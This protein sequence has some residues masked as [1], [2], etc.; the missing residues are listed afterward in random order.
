MLVERSLRG[1]KLKSKREG[2]SVDWRI[3]YRRRCPFTFEEA[4]GA[5]VM[6]LALW[7]FPGTTFWWSLLSVR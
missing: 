7:E 6:Q 4:G 3:V 1:E 2:L 5:G